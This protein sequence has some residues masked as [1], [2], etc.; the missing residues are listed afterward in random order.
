MAQKRE[1]EIWY[2][3]VKREWKLIVVTILLGA[4]L[5][6]LFDLW[7][8]I[9]TEF[10]APVNESIWEHGKIVF[11]PLLLVFG[12]KCG[13]RDSEKWLL[14]ALCATLAVLLAG[15]TWHVA[16]GGTQLSVD[17]VIYAV[18]ICLAFCL[19][20][21]LPLRKEAAPVALGLAIIFAA[22][23]F[24]FT[25]NPPRGTLFNDPSLADAW[26]IMTC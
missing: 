17:L 8:S 3:I 19:A 18:G 4:G 1:W 10:F 11:W 16:L 5:H 12:L 7:P 25:L 6:F 21:R 15:W 26:V 24:A 20:E 2:R 13:T 9:V 23:I 22:L 14:A